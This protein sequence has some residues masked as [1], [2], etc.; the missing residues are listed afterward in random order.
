MVGINGVAQASVILVVN[1]Q[2]N[3]GG[4][5]QWLRRKLRRKKD[6]EADV[7]ANGHLPRIIM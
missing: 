6:Q 2:N 3:K 1:K 7:E 5:P 4:H